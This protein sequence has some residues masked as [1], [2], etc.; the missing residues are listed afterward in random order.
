MRTSI[1]NNIAA[2]HIGYIPPHG[3]VLDQ[4]E[5][6]VIDGDLFSILAAGGPG[7]RYQ[8]NVQL[9]AATDEI[10]SGDVTITEAPLPSSS[11]P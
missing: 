5:E 2:R 1:T 10:E 7:G 4:D 11:A 6:I 8:K 9:A 3:R